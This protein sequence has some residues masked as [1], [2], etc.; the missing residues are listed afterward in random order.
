MLTHSYRMQFWWLSEMSL[1]PLDWQQNFYTNPRSLL[2]N[3]AILS[4]RITC[5]GWQKDM[6]SRGRGNLLAVVYAVYMRKSIKSGS[7]LG[8]SVTLTT[9]PPPPH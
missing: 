6:P 7:S 5:F 1:K 3:W 2:T 8:T 9:R 4:C